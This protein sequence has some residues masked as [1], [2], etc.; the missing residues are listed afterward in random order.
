[1]STIQKNSVVGIHYTLTDTEGEVLDSTE[2]ETP[3]LYLHGV[4]QLVPGL[5]SKLEGAK[6][7]DVCKVTVTPENGYGE[8]DEELQ[9][10]VPRDEFPEDMEFEVDMQFAAESGEGHIQ[11]FRVLGVGEDT[12]SVDGNHPLAGQTLHFEV[13]IV[14]LRDATAEEIEHGHAHGEGGHHH[15]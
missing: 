5:E 11:I 7:G 9:M 4:G 3:M 1:M 13:Q 2:G 14:S 6:I 15:H 12:I 8:F 10:E